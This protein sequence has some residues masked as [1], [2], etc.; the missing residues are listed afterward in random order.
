MPVEVAVYQQ[1]ALFL[2][3]LDELNR[4]IRYI[5]GVVDS[6]VCLPAGIYPL[7]VKISPKQIAAVVSVNDSIDIEH[8]YDLEDEV[9][10]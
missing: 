3:L 2:D 5:F 6:G 7:P 4:S 8:R 1:L 9:V 10:A